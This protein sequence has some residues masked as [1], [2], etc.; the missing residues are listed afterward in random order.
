MR[1]T[2]LS[3]LALFLLLCFTALAQDRTV[4]GKVISADDSSPLPGV[5]VVVKGTTA[6]SVTDL[7]G[8]YRII[9]PQG[10]THLTYSF[11][12]YTSKE[13]EIGTQ[14]VIDVALASD[15]K[16]LEEVVVTAIGIERQKREIAYGVQ[17]VES[18]AI[19]QKSEPNVLN[20]LQGKMAGVEIISNSGVPGSSTQIFIRGISSATG[21]NQPLFVIDGVPVDNS[22]SFSQGGAVSGAAYSNRALDI[23]P[24]DIESMTVLKGPAAA[25]LY[26]SRASNGAIMI[27]TKKGKS[28]S[29][30]EVTYTASYNAQSVMGLPNY[31]NQYG[32]GQGGSFN[33][34]LTDSWGPRFG[35]GVT[36]VPVPAGLANVIGATTVPYQAYE[37]NVKD[38]FRRGDIWDNGISLSGGGEKTRYILSLN[39]TNQSG[40]LPNTGLERNSVRVAGDAK[41]ANGFSIDATLNFINTVQ[42]G[43]Q[44]GNSGLSPWF[45]LPFVPR[46]YDLLGF[47]YK[48][49]NSS[50]SVTIPGPTL[51]T[52]QNRENPLWAV[53]ENPYR[54]EVNRIITSASINYEPS[55]VKNLKLTYRA[56][57][58]QYQDNRKEVVAYGTLVGN[59]AFGANRRGAQLYDDISS[60]QITHD[61]FASYD[62]NLTQDINLRIL[63][64]TQINERRSSS[65]TVTAQDLIIPGFYNLSNHASSNIISSNTTTKR[66]IIGNYAQLG[67]SYKDYL[68]LELQGRVD[69]SST[70]PKDNNTY[71]YPAAQLGFIFTDA[72]KIKNDFL[73]YGK[74]RLNYARVGAD[75]DP[76]LINTVYV[77]SGF[78]NNV[79]GIDFPYNGN[80]N[81]FTL[82]NRAGNLDLKPEFKNSIEIGGEFVFLNGKINLDVNYFSTSQTEQI[83]NIAV[84]ASS[85]FTTQT[86]N[87]GE[88]T[89]KGWEVLLDGNILKNDNGLNWNASLNFTRIRNEVVSLAPGVELLRI[90][91]PAG[92]FFGGLGSAIIPNQPYGVLIGNT[93]VRDGKGGFLINPNTG[94]PLIDNTPNQ[95]IGDP[96]PDWTAGLTNTLTYKGLKL[97][98]LLQYVHGGDFYSRQLQIA[99]L[100][101]VLEEQADNREVP[102]MFQGTLANPDGT[103][104]SNANNIQITAQDYWIALNN[105]SEFAVFD[106]TVLRLR[107]ISLGYDL[108]K[109]LLEKT[110]FGSLNVT[111]SGRNLFFFAPNLKHADPETNSLNGNTRG[112]EFNSPPSV[113]NYGVNLRATF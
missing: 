11:V 2:L 24:N 3:T 76:Y 94:L 40:I 55:F 57:V 7:D 63:L 97:N 80:T 85:G 75:A 68:F 39:N 101:G 14:T 71:F 47:P 88:I 59:T 84:P 100:R 65:V 4:T 30:M 15:V 98:V 41:L 89:N 32:Q 19:A 12:G 60:F 56:G 17:Q 42:T 66:R 61:A 10:G 82:S 26:G 53:N 18:G 86:G 62:K 48:L 70:L 8:K 16:Q 35:A 102:F 107:E 45:T 46:S 9:V 13:V 96:N 93:F 110:P 83:Y 108:P 113:R 33:N 64:G 44:Q 36:Q 23:N 90:G 91:S 112:F 106:A 103:A 51:W 25:A 28:G 78:G 81:A 72:F 31:Q 104:S 1:K 109:R 95:I 50:P 111:L 74:L 6:G 22:T 105:A 87:G 52:L 92:N 43:I 5:A 21:N 49:P 77:S 37:N 54:S 79:S 27:T 20:A 73:S 67:L 58:D 38:F 34:A 69:K 99:R 29:K